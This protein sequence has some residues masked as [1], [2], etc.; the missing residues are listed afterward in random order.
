MAANLAKAQQRANLADFTVGALGLWADGVEYRN[1]SSLEVISA[2]FPS[3]PSW[4]RITI[5]AINRNIFANVDVWADT[6]GVTY[7]R[8]VR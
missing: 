5:L 7:S 6:H 1:K 3:Q 8:C 2:N 4:D